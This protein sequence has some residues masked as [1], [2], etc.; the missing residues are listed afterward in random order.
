MKNNNRSKEPIK[1]VYIKNNDGVLMR[2]PEECAKQIQGK[3]END[4]TKL[5]HIIIPEKCI[6]N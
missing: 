3:G 1:F 5:K 6:N 2:V 4:N